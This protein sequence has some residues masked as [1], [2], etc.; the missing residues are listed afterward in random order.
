MFGHSVAALEVQVGTTWGGG[1][2]GHAKYSAKLV[3]LYVGPT[4]MDGFYR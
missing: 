1:G 3:N 4:G 2:H